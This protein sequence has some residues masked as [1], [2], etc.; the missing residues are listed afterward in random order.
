MPSLYRKYWQQGSALRK[1]GSPT[2]PF[3]FVI[4]ISLR[5]D[6]LQ[7]SYERVQG[8]R[9][10]GLGKCSGITYSGGILSYFPRHLVG[11]W[12][13]HVSRLQG[14]ILKSVILDE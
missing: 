7:A 2:A 12:G 3:Y 14:A 1:S 9:N 8:A 11:T 10:D 5:A 6:L 4:N 13:L